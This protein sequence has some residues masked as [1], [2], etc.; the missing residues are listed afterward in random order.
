MSILTLEWCFWSAIGVILYTYIG[1]PL[2]LLVLRP[3]RSVHHPTNE[4][5]AL[6]VVVAAYNEASC[7]AEKVRNLLE[8]DYPGEM[9]VIVVSDGST[10]RTEEIVRVLE[11]P[12]VTLLIQPNRAGKNE[13]INR[14]VTAARGD[15]IVLTDA[16]AMLVK[17]SLCELVMSFADPA[18]GL[19][20]GQGLY[21]DSVAIADGATEAVGNAYV[22]YEAFLKGRES[23]LGFLPGAD[24]ALY[25]LR[26]DVCVR[27]PSEMVHDL[28]HPITVALDGMRS[29]FVPEAVTLEPPSRDAS[30]EFER[31]RRISA[32]GYRVFF[33]RV[34]ALLI[35]RKGL[36]LW[37]LVSHRFL[38]WTS[39][40]P[41]LVA[42]VSNVLLVHV[43]PLYGLALGVQ[44][45]FYA[46]AAVGAAAEHF[47]LRTRLLALP[48][49]FCVV[50]VAGLF[51]F[52][53]YLSGAPQHTWQSGRAQA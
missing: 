15:L 26:R 19:V 9:E 39:S 49:F 41:L 51:G 50:S 29:E 3:G 5:P 17:G 8:H 32:Q 35:A 22:R 48:Y 53:R 2:F 21:G 18:V 1:Y 12:Q 44:V 13:A 24:G 4:W 16:N 27:L 14:G 34:G 46:A 20:S 43:G 25:A 42:F 6:S 11:C 31:H 33:S 30:T 45:V 36:A 47:G 23:S 40:V 52:A 7:I 38:R 10:D 28:L 37:V